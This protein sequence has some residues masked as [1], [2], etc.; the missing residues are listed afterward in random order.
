[1]TIS[2]NELKRPSKDCNIDFE[3]TKPVGDALETYHKASSR[4]RALSSKRD[5]GSKESNNDAIKLVIEQDEESEEIDSS[6]EVINQNMEKIVIK[7]DPE[8]TRTLNY[9]SESPQ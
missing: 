9:D 8:M 1:M 7:G 3:N 2:R 4:S 5:I 6:P